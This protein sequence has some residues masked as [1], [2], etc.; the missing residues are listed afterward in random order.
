MAMIMCEGVREGERLG[1]VVEIQGQRNKVS[2]KGHQTLSLVG[3]VSP[4]NKVGQ[5]LTLLLLSRTAP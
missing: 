4:Q 5:A 1:T 3:E 2:Q